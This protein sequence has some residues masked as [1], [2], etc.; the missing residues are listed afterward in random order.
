MATR[1]HKEGLTDEAAQLRAR[2]EELE[3]EPVLA[4]SEYCNAFRAWAEAI[5][6]RIEREPDAE[7]AERWRRCKRALDELPLY[8]LKSNLLAR[9]IYC[10]EEVRTTPCPAHKGHWSGCVWEDL[11]CGCVAHGNVTGWLPDDPEAAA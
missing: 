6:A 7:E 5:A 2:L 11:P 10:G 3:G 8:I 1:V 4:A 9:L